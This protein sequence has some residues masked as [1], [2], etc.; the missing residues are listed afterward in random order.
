M[1]KLKKLGVILSMAAAG[2][3]MTAA[4]VSAKI[5]VTSQIK[6]TTNFAVIVTNLT[7]ERR[8]KFDKCRV[9]DPNR[10][11]YNS[12]I[13]DY[14]NKYVSLGYYVFDLKAMQREGLLDYNAEQKG[15][16][17]GIY[18]VDAY[19]KNTMVLYIAN[20]S[21]EG[22]EK[23]F[24]GGRKAQKATDYSSTSHNTTVQRKYIKDYTPSTG[25]IIYSIICDPGTNMNHI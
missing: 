3:M 5:N 17:D 22:Y 10:M 14:A 24:L 16:T 6:N 25:I 11:N 12:F 21:P 23:G 4:P 1:R 18:V 7:A 20:L 2:S 9:T 15:L 19:E 13:R 8:Q